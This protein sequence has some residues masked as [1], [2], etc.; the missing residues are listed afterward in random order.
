MDQTTDR[1]KT[2]PLKSNIR[3]GG[4]CKNVIERIMNII[5]KDKSLYT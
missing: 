1:Q 2:R 5:S 3:N 4:S